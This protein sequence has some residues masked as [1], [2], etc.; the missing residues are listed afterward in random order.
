MNRRSS[1]WATF[2]ALTWGI[3]FVVIDAGLHDVPPL[4]F[5]AIRFTIVVIPAI[6]LVPRPAG[7]FRDVAVV[8][9]LMGLGQFGLL[10]VALDCG[11]PPG[12]AAL[13]IQTQVL[14]TVIIARVHLAERLSRN[15]TVGLVVGAAGL[16]IVCLGRA[17]T[18]PAIGLLLTLAAALSW[19]I[20]NIAS[21]K[22]GSTSG[23]SLTVWSSTVVPLPMLGL[24]LA[25]EGPTRIAYAMGH[26]PVSAV[27]STAY[28]A[29][30]STLLGFGIWNSLLARYPA[31]NVTPFALLVPPAGIITAWLAQGEA[32]GWA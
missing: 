25:L 27:L 26:L 24:S 13:L 2:V 6:F 19:A 9:L 8:G 1:L 29:Y 14:L 3:N 17:T 30:V 5:L 10:Y 20:G 16:G 12:L 11:M 18:T 4:L 21:R 22:V 7:P 23:L 32:P 15:Q 28:T 31:A